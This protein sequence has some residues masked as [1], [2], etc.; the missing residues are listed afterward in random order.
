MA[1]TYNT[2]GTVAPGD[3]LRANSGTAAYNDV[4]EN[5]NNNRV[6]PM[7][8]VRR[9]T[10]Q[11]GY[12]S[13]AAITWESVQ[14]TSDTDTM[15]SAGDAT[16]VSIT[17][18]GLYVVTFTGRL[19]ATATMTLCN[20]NIVLN[21]AFVASATGGVQSGTT[22]IFAIA[23]TLLLANGDYLQA[24]VGISGGSAYIVQGNT[25]VANNQTRL[26]VTWQG[27]VS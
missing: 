24:S 17:T 19:N 1:K 13:D 22:G 5:V 26:A 6:P 20:P 8:I 9:T 11:T 25:N 15:W 7:C 2:L 3:V 12:T 16:K 21:G 10:N 23:T 4:L 18:P 14:P 27:Q